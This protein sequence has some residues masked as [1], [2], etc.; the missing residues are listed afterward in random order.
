M[1]EKQFGYTAEEV[2]GQDPINVMVEDR[3]A[4]F[5][6]SFLGFQLKTNWR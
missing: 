1:S 3:D 6:T 4:A 5:V 2:V